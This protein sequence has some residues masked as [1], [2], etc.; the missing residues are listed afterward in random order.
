[1]WVYAQVLRTYSYL[2]YLNQDWQEG[3]GGELRI[4]SDNGRDECVNALYIIALELEDVSIVGFDAW[5]A[6]H[7]ACLTS[8]DYVPFGGIF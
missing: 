7:V 4:H 6:I 2:L 1:M 5:T 8:I 3:D